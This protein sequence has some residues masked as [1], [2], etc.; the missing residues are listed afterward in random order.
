MPD[1]FSSTTSLGALI[2]AAGRA[3]GAKEQAV[4]DGPAVR[5]GLRSA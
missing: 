1:I 3:A 2:L 5:L 4:S